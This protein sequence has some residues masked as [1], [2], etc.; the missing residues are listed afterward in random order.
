MCHGTSTLFRRMDLCLLPRS[1]IYIIY[2]YIIY[3][4]IPFKHQ[5]PDSRT[6]LRVLPRN[7]S[8]IF[9]PA[10]GWL[11]YLFSWDVWSNPLRPR[12]GACLPPAT[13]R[14]VLWRYN[15]LP[16]E[17]TPMVTIC[18]WCFEKTWWVGIFTSRKLYKLSGKA[19]VLLWHDDLRFM[20]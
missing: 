8:H 3:I 6:F 16:R 2:M 13:W 17:K 9:T 10:E 19:Q 7:R 15:H 5:Y 1:G 4:Y 14:E 12:G 11:A 20:V 18:Q